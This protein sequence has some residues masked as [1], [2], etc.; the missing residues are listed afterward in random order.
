MSF[1]V[2]ILLIQPTDTPID[3]N[4]YRIV[5]YEA[6]QEEAVKASLYAGKNL[7]IDKQL[8]DNNFLYKVIGENTIVIRPVNSFGCYEEYK[9]AI[10]KIAEYQVKIFP[11]KELR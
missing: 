7:Y 3:Y 10:L 1:L 8:P 6:E 11:D 4:L 9:E 2:F 5:F